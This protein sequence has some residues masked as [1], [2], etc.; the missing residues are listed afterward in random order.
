MCTPENFYVSFYPGFV[1]DSSSDDFRIPIFQTGYLISICALKQQLLVI[2]KHF[3]DFSRLPLIYTKSLARPF[4]KYSWS[5]LYN[6]AC[7]EV[8][9]SFLHLNLNCVFAVEANRKRGA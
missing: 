3:L 2:I 7:S 9:L 5:L 1:F 4:V 8:N 6:D